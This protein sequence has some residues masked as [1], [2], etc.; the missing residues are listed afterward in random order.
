MSVLAGCSNFLD[1]PAAISDPNLP[2]AATRD[3]LFVGAQ[4]NIFGQQEGPLAMIV[5][6]WMQQCAGVNGR[7]VQQQDSYSVNAGTFDLSFQGV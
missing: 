3:Q 7:F 5:C 4:A 1:A 2:S 6:Q